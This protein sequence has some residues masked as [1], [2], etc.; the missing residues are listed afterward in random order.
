MLSLSEVVF[1]IINFYLIIVCVCCHPTPGLLCYGP[2]PGVQYKYSYKSETIMNNN[3]Y[4]EPTGFGVDSQ[5]TVENIW[6]DSSGY[7]LSV[8]IDSCQFKSRTGAK[9]ADGNQIKDWNHPLFAYIDSTGDV[10]QVVIHQSEVI[11]ASNLKKS[12]LEHLRSKAPEKT[13]YEWIRDGLTISKKSLNTNTDYKSILSPDV[14][15][16]WQTSAQLASDHPIVESANGWQ[17]VTL[18]SRIYSFAHSKLYNSFTLKLLSEAKSSREKIT[19]N[20]ISD[21]IKSLGETYIHTEPILRP[22]METCHN[23]Q[24]LQNIVKENE[25]SIKGESIASIP[26]TISYLKLI[27]RVRSA[28]PGASKEDIIKLLKA[29]KKKKDVVSSILDILAGARTEQSLAAALEYLNLQK[30]EDLDFGERFLVQLAASVMTASQMESISSA[31]VSADEVIEEILKQTKTKWKNEKLK[32]TAF[33]ILATLLRAHVFDPKKTDCRVVLLHAIGNTGLIRDGVYQSIK[34]YSLTSGKR[35]SIAAM[36]AL[37]EC[38]QLSGSNDK[39]TPRLRSLLLRVVYD[40]EQETTSRVIAAELISIYLNDEKTAKELIKHLPTFGNNELATIIW[41]RAFS[42]APLIPT[43]HHNWHLHST[44]LNGSSAS[45]TRVMGGTKSTNA[46][47][48]ILMELL[49]KGKLLKESAFDVELSSPNGYSQHLITVGMFARGLQS[50]AG[51]S[52]AE[53]PTNEVEEEQ[54]MAGMSLRIMN[55]QL[56]PFTFF[57][58]TGE[59]MGHVWSGTA[60]EPTT[61]FQ[62]NFLLADYWSTH[63]LINGLIVEQSLRGILSLDLSGEIQISLWNRNSHSVVHTKGSLLFQGSQTVLTSDHKTSASKQFSF[64]GNTQLDFITDLDFYSSPFK[65]CMQIDRPEFTF[66]HNTRKY[67]RV[68]SENLHKRIHRRIFSIP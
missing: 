11:T 51:D 64:G 28:G 49:N 14:S 7:L 32:Q 1:A 63:P 50:F 25:N 40:P 19:A 8:V 6:Q 55:I 62:G 57:T 47:Y 16:E 43:A 23:C 65:M 54:T 44:T 36:K 45:F 13:S 52:E 9:F 24:S 58:G 68:N 61:V 15:D 46:S 53:T 48:R 42:S 35:E 66:R 56:R 3:D 21:V 17:N 22:E 37:R 33:L 29:Y 34:K 20:S 59:L 31:T 27:D 18:Q 60:S 39:L 5:I 30:S 10:K 12:L 26:M 4:R 2:L 67:E 38:L 41:N